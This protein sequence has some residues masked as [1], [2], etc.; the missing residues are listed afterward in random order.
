MRTV[1]SKAVVALSVPPTL[2]AIAFISWARV[3][4]PSL[5]WVIAAWMLGVLVPMVGF[6][7]LAGVRGWASEAFVRLPARRKIACL[8]GAAVGVCLYTLGVALGPYLG[9]TSSYILAGGS[10]SLAFASLLQPSQRALLFFV[11]LF[12]GVVFIIT[13]GVH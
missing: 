8:A 3:T 11:S 4:A 12:V 9:D 6:F 13:A 5:R 2:G 1:K 10:G 7:Q